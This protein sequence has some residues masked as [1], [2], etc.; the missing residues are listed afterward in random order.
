METIHSS[1]ASVITRG[2]RRNIPED[3]IFYMET[4]FMASSTEVKGEFP[5]RQWRG[6]RDIKDGEGLFGGLS[7]GIV[8]SRTKGHGVSKRVSSFK[9]VVSSDL[10][11][12]DEA[13]V[14]QFGIGTCHAVCLNGVKKG[15]TR[16]SV[17]RLPGR[18]MNAA[19]LGQDA[20]ASAIRPSFGNFRSVFLLFG[21]W[22]ETDSAWYIGH[23]WPVVA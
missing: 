11:G 12:M 19:P 16:L 1:E 20:R 8:R 22:P 4:S 23:T 14:S 9:E 18:C 17:V 7:V 15:E 13:F 2:T 3:G 21:R 10:M 6:F 5:P